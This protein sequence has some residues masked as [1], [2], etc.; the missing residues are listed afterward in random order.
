[1][2]EVHQLSRQD[3]RRVAVRA[4]LLDARRPTDVQDVVRHLTLVQVD[5]VMTVAPSH[6][7]VLWSRL[8][9]RYAPA[10]LQAALGARVLVELQMMVRPAEDVA[11]YLADMAAWPG[12]EPLKDWE[13]SVREWVTANDACRRDLL[14]RL[15][16]LGP[17]RARDLPDTCERPWGSSGWNDNRNVGRLLEM[18]EARGEVAVCG[19]QG[20]DRLWDLAERVYPDV[21]ALP[22]EEATRIRDERRLSALGIARVKAPAQPIEPVHVGE[23]GE[24]AVVDGVPG[25]W[26][27]APEALEAAESDRFA[28]RTALLSPFDRLSY[29]R[30]RAKQLFD[31][32]YYLEMYKPEAKRRWGYFALPIL[33]GDRLVGKVD[34]RADRKAGVL[35]V[36]AIHEDAPFGADMRDAVL[37]ELDALAEW[38][39]V[40]RVGP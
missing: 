29:D 3:A 35:R 32:E 4:Q 34:A 25:T 12:A 14:Q 2:P 21:E 13:R 18:M 7:L 30:V 20:R 15:D 5:H 16:R 11:L 39:D 17:Q 9:S 36:N 19:H 33:H 26:R 23:A 24:E 28:G 1:V 40:E 22:I 10:E 37:A 38:L 27:I 31:F 8:G 6:D